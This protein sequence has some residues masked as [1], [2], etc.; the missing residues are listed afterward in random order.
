VRY[1]RTDDL[2]LVRQ[3]AAAACSRRRPRRAARPR[4]YVIPTIPVA[5]RV[6]AYVIP[7]GDLAPLATAVRSWLDMRTVA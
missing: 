7:L 5:A 4:A 2:N 3:L 1:L 6:R